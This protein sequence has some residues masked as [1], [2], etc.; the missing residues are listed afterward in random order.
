MEAAGGGGVD[1][2]G[3]GG[4]DVAEFIELERAAG[5][6]RFA[7]GVELGEFGEN[8]GEHGAALLAN[9]F[10]VF[11]DGGEPELEHVG[12]GAREA[13]RL[14]L[15]GCGSWD[16]LPACR[17]SRRSEVEMTGWKPIPL[18]FL[19]WLRRASSWPRRWR[20]SWNGVASSLDWRRKRL[21]S[22]LSLTAVSTRGLE[23]D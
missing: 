16:R 1:I 5:F 12:S 22:S 15:R 23:P 4:D 3:S 20:V 6:G 13:S 11:E 7:T 8:R 19:I 14:P 9:V 21:I 10:A 18:Y 2:D 17:V